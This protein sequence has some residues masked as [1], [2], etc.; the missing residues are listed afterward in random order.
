[1]YRKV[2]KLPYPKNPIVNSDYQPRNHLFGRVEPPFFEPTSKSRASVDKGWYDITFHQLRQMDGVDTKRYFD[3]LKT[4]LF[5][6]WEEDGT[7]PSIGKTERQIIDGFSKLKDYDVDSLYKDV[8]IPD[9]IAVIKDFT[10]MWSGINQ[11]FPNML[12]TRINGRSMWDWFSNWDLSVEFR[13]VMVRAC[14]NDGMYSY[15]KPFGITDNPN[16]TKL[17]LWTEFQHK[18]KDNEDFFVTKNGQIRIYDK[19]EKLFPKIIQIFRLGLGQPPTNFPPLT[20]R[21]IYEKYLGE[22][23]NQKQFTIYDPCAG[24]GGRLIGA[25]SSKMKIHYVGI[26]PN[27]MEYYDV[28]VKGLLGGTKKVNRELFS[29]YDEL[30]DFYNKHCNG[31]N[32]FEVIGDIAEETIT[33]PYMKKYIGECDLVFTSP[34]YFDREQYSEDDSQSMNRYKTYDKWKEKFLRKLIESSYEFLKDNRYM[35]IN[36]ADIKRGESDYI[37]MEQDTISLAIGCGFWYFGKMEMVMSRMIG[38]NP[39]KVKN[40]F[41]DEDDKK[42]YKTEP[43]LVFKK[44][45][46]GFDD[47]PPIKDEESDY[48][49]MYEYYNTLP[50]ED[51]TKDE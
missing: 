50:D 45:E 46:S 5:Q 35:I 9:T 19:S 18:L 16:I 29:S 21:L 42:D 14:K 13:R 49:E 51:S 39:S 12:K 24:W 25:L 11:F 36:I 27:N 23:E 15:S 37:P 20:A 47:R 10:K 2:P 8:E 26:D 32:T 43:I 17:D 22:I 31:K 6:I 7:P 34:P 28:P 3:M 33:K 40:T 41:F 1:M 30:G 44:D 48:L 4:E 38:V